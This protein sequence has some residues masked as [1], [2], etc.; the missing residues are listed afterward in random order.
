MGVMLAILIAVTT[1]LIAPTI[2]LPETTLNDHQ[3]TF[4][5]ISRGHA[6]GRFSV[7]PSQILRLGPVAEGMEKPSADTEHSPHRRVASAV[8]LRC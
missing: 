5:H 7:T 4:L 1:V 6:L 8:V 2:D 3:V